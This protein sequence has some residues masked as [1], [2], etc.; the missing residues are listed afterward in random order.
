MNAVAGIEI[1]EDLDHAPSDAPTSQQDSGDL[2]WL[3]D[4]ST[5]TIAAYPP[6]FR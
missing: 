6:C 2:I 1:T 3:L 5:V 4:G